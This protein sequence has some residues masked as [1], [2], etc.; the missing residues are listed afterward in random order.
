MKIALFAENYYPYICGINPILR[1]LLH[2]LKDAG[3]EVYLVVFNVPR[4]YKENKD[5]PQIIML[6][7]MKTFKF[8]RD[9]FCT[10]FCFNRKKNLEFLDKYKFDVIHVHGEYSM[11]KMALAYAKRNNIPLVYTWHSL[12]KDIMYKTVWLPGLLSAAYVEHINIKRLVNYSDVYTVPSMK[13]YKRAMKV[14]RARKEPIL[15]PSGIQVEPFL[16]DN[17]EKIEQIRYQYRFENKKVILFLGRI[18]REKRI[19]TIIRYMKKM[20]KNDDSLRVAIVG[21]GIYSTHIMKWAKRHKLQDSII[22]SGPVLNRDT[23][24]FYHLASVFVSGSKMETQG[25]TYIEAMA[26]GRVV[27]A[28]KDPVLDGVIE[29]GKNGFTFSKK[30]D[31]LFKL[32]YIL[33]NED[34]LDNLKK[35]AVTKG[36]EYSSNIYIEKLQKIYQ[37]AIENHKNKEKSHA[38]TTK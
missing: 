36:L 29:D 31:F 15:L 5:N 28:Q 14:L 11:S 8:I 3:H 1:T 38:K 18:S 12:W 4:V 34:K 23:T 25:L 24:D 33:E 22:F 35:A 32:H 16:E 37:E 27:L 19:L 7:G 6:K 13:V 10:S 17:K 20:L 2:R 26:S 9:G 30:K 21:S